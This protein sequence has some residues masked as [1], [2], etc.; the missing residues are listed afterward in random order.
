LAY[1]EVTSAGVTLGADNGDL[2]TAARVERIRDPN[3]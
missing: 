1:D 3:L 2:L